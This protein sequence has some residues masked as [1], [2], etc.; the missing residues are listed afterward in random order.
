MKKLLLLSALAF[1]AI[2]SQAVTF[3]VTVMDEEIQNGATVDAKCLVVNEEEYMGMQFVNYQLDPEVYASASEPT[4]VS[5]TVTNYFIEHPADQPNLQF[6]W[7]LGSQCTTPGYMGQPNPAVRQGK[8]DGNPQFLFIDSAN[9]DDK[10][11]EGFTM[12]CDV[13]IRSLA[14]PSDSFSFKLNMI[15]DPEMLGVD[16]VEADDAPATYYDIAGRRVYNPQKGQLVIERR[17]AKA[18]KRIL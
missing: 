6:C 5:I 3:N 12:S 7:P 1:S 8:L 13:M 15:Y 4:D 17:G 11:E 9:W 16:G 18:T 2:A 10:I 14:N